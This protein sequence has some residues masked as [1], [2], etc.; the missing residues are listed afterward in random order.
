MAD[1]DSRV[2]ARFVFWFAAAA[3]AVGLFFYASFFRGVVSGAAEWTG[4]G[5]IWP[6]QMFHNFVH[7]RP[8]QSS[9][10][11]V[12]DATGSA[13]GFISNPY[14]FINSNAIHINWLPYLF[15][16]LWALHQTPAW[17]Y[18][19]EVLW[20][21]L[22][23]A[24][25]ASSILRRLDPEGWRPKLA[26]CLAILISSGLLSILNQ[27]G[28]LLSFCGPLILAVYDAALA[29]R[30]GWFLFWI[31]ALCLTA[32]DAAMAAFVFSAYFVVFEREWRTEGLLAA[33]LS[34]AYLVL[35][36][37]V[38]QPASR[39]ELSVLT[40]TTTTFVIS[41]ALHM[42]LSLIA[43]NLF[44][45]LPV[46]TLL[47]AAGVAAALYGVPDRRDRLILAALSL[48][49]G[50][51]HWGECLVVGGAHHLFPCYFG[52]YLGLVVLVG[53]GRGGLA[54]RALAGWAAVYALVSLRALIGNAPPEMKLPLLR[55][56]RP[57]QAEALERSLRG[58]RESN[59]ALIAA[60]RALGPD[61]SV[62][63]LGNDRAE[64]YVVQRS[65]VWD[66][67]DY[68]DQT[69]YLL[70]QKDAIDLNFPFSPAP[71]RTLAESVAHYVRLNVRETPLAPEAL[72][73]IR[74]T[75]VDEK[76]THRVSYEDAHVLV[77]EN[78]APSTP[79]SAP[80]TYGFGWW[81]NVGRKA[82]RADLFSAPQR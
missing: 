75:L 23:S 78:L 36:L 44:S 66:F 70:V 39:A 52:L 49:P 45:M 18:A 33:G 24:F 51:A 38:I 47:P 64:G 65:D 54:P 28:Q 3:A 11:A 58:E 40:S 74:R 37:G 13:V 72:A 10:Y 12:P 35:A 29:R 2:R 59:R 14:G 16:P 21:V 17:L 76:K 19:I 42:R 71:G 25:F 27:M 26:V 41:H 62:C 53:R 4:N 79:F 68:Y 73:L 43:S 69:R 9:L 5:F 46:A 60:S 81:P 30:R 80:S 56:A 31:L 6:I 50:A 20:C 48:A 55:V 1:G 63:F 34:G 82:K 57:A 22:G 15:A 8:F 61:A 32:E 67:P 7:G 77:L